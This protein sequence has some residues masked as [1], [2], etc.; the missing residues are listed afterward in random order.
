MVNGVYQPQNDWKCVPETR[1]KSPTF[2]SP[3][4]GNNVATGLQIG[5]AVLQIIG[6]LASQTQAT[7]NV[8]QA[9]SDDAMHGTRSRGFNRQAIGLQQAGK[10]DEARI[11]F[12]K[13]A[14]E[15]VLAGNLR[16][17]KANE[18]NA[19]IADSLHWLR[20]GYDAEKA[21]KPTKANISYRMGID[22]ATRAGNA[23]LVSKL[24]KA[25]DQ[26]VKGKG[27]GQMLKSDRKNCELINGKYG[28]H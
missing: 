26:L 2:T 13:A 9:Q 19:D 17:A 3:G 5:G 1:Q 21:G 20:N 25:N 14:N 22:A 28:C 18:K 7:D 12:M 27:D 4:G 24:S 10:F 8:G 23:S 15:A 11:A 16:E 6:A